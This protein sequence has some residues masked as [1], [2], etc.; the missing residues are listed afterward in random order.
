VSLMKHTKGHL[1]NYTYLLIQ[2]QSLTKVMDFLTSF[3]LSFL[4]IFTKR[5][6]ELVGSK[7]QSQRK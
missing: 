5:I 6:M 2:P 3:I 7:Q 4:L 1:I